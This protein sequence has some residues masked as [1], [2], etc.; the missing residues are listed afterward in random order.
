MGAAQCG[1]NGCGS[2]NGES[3]PTSV[4]VAAE[5]SAENCED[6]LREELETKLPHMKDKPQAKKVKETRIAA[7]AEKRKPTINKDVLVRRIDKKYSVFSTTTVVTVWKPL[8]VTVVSAKGLRNA[9]WSILGNKSDPYCVCQIRAK[10]L[11]KFV[12]EVVDNDLSPQWNCEGVFRDYEFGDA[13]DFFVFDKDWGKKDDFLGKATLESR[14]FH[15]H[16]FEGTL[17]LEEAGKTFLGKKVDAYLTVKVGALETKH[18]SRA[19]SKELVKSKVPDEAAVAEPEPAAEEKGGE[20][21]EEE[22]EEDEEVAEEPE[23]PSPEG[24]DVPS[25]AT[26]SIPSPRPSFLKSPSG[27]FNAPGD[28]SWLS[29]VLRSLATNDAPKLG[30]IN[31][32]SGA[33]HTPILFVLGSCPNTFCGMQAVMFC[34]D[35]QSTLD[36]WWVKPSKDNAQTLEKKTLSRH[37]KGPHKNDPGRSKP[38]YQPLADLFQ[39]RSIVKG[40]RFG[41]KKT[42]SESG[43]EAIRAFIQHEAAGPQA[44]KLYLVMLWQEDWTSNPFSR[45]KYIKGKL[46]YHKKMDPTPTFYSRQYEIHDGLAHIANF[47]DIETLSQMMPPSS[48]KN[49]FDLGV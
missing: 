38:F 5:K 13:L 18:V 34:A 19:K 49:L 17:K 42:T 28:Y 4:S 44:D 39:E 43:A 37:S 21:E 24:N 16:G 23:L 22:E 9:D 27:N 15:P 36:F 11:S 8:N 33:R 41:T 45:R 14:Q 25:S 7:S 48:I 12:T 47:E 20:E 29:D 30:C 1:A 26:T 31:V 32:D 6:P 10:P 2:C 46:I 35:A 40:W 3:S